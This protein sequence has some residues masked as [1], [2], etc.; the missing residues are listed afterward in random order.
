MFGSQVFYH[1][2]NCAV[3]CK[4]SVTLHMLSD[5]QIILHTVDPRISIPCSSGISDYP[6]TK[7]NLIRTGAIR[8]SR[9]RMCST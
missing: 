9:V 5:R 6:D 2:K 7:L 3:I 4:D 1:P 8:K